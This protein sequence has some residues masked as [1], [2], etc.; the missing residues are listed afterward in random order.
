MRPKAPITVILL[1]LV[2]LFTGLAGVP[3]RGDEGPTET[4]TLL[5]ELINQ[6]RANPLDTAASLGMDPDQILADFP[7]LK[8]VLTEGLPPLRFNADLYRAAAGHTADMIARGYYAHN[9]LPVES[10]EPP[11]GSPWRPDQDVTTYVDRIV[12]E[13]YEPAVSGETLGFLWFTNY[14]DA[15]T[16]AALLFQNMFRNELDPTFTD[17]RNI[18]NAELREVGV[19][20][21]AGV[22]SV[23]GYQI[24]AYI[25]T[26]DF[27]AQEAHVIE[28]ELLALI[29][30][31]RENPLGMALAMGM[32]TEQVLRDLP[33]FADMLTAGLGPLLYNRRLAESAAAHAADMLANWY[34]SYF[35]LDGRGPW[36]RIAEAG[37]PAMLTGETI[38]LIASLCDAIPAEVATA[39]FEAAFRDELSPERL[40]ERYML[41]P[42]LKEGG[43]A[44]NGLS[45]CEGDE[46]SYRYDLWVAD[47]G[48][49][50]NGPGTT[51][52][53][54]VFDD[55][56]E[57]G[58]YGPGEGLPGVMVD[59]TTGDNTA[60]RV[61]TDAAGGFRLAV[62]PGIYQV[63]VTVGESVLVQVLELGPGEVK[64][65]WV[66]VSGGV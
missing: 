38:G 35:S 31:A 65:V 59:V 4:E 15:Q 61:P 12:A 2:V 63:A 33:E 9:S 57:N 26:L 62:E 42:D 10:E 6:A 3:V 43:I 8:H 32:D 19:S 50:E 54:M 40:G 41:S 55:T 11:P 27:G 53:G 48:A 51:L 24:N 25:A 5:L 29:N 47:F 20:L 7:N 21:Q 64:S 44:F 23:D 14:I 60:Y 45:L 39:L 16:A 49:R 17:E 1:A 66:N 13:G 34:F 52:S 46:F 56:D 37:Y 28:S 30:Q 36:D 22:F 58:L 18:I